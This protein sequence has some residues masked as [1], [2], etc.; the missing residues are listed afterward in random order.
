MEEANNPEAPSDSSTVAA[1]GKKGMTMCKR[2]VDKYS[3]CTDASFA[4]MKKK[5]AAMKKK[6]NGKRSKEAGMI[7]KVND[8]MKD[9]YTLEL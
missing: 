2:F 1:K 4:D 9:A 6:F 7:K 3:C 5:F 8:T